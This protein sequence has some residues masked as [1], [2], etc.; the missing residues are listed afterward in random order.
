MTVSTFNVSASELER[1]V[2]D[3]GHYDKDAQEYMEQIELAA[4]IRR[5]KDRAEQERRCEAARAR[6]ERFF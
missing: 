4:S 3:A 6:R 1:L 5:A 2:D